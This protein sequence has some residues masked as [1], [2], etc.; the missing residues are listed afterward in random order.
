MRN[1]GRTNRLYRQKSIGMLRNRYPVK[2]T[3]AENISAEEMIKLDTVEFPGNIV[4]VEDTSD[5][6]SICTELSVC[7]AIGF[8]TETRP[9]FKPGIINKV[10]LLQL[11]TQDTCYLFRLCRIPLHKA[12]IKVLEDKNI[13]KIGADVHNDLLALKELRHFK[14][15]GFLDLQDIIHEWGITEKS[16]RKMSSIVLG[17]RVS[18]AKRLSNWAAV[19]LTP[20]QMMYAATDA[21][22]CLRIYDI[23]KKTEKKPLLPKP[24]AGGDKTESRAGK[25]RE[26]N[27]KL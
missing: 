5:I 24:A 20:R 16:V 1:K 4:V 18:K 10:A 9:S 3:F 13:I 6:E 22:V 23:L 25:K 7:P 19:S 2:N 26:V 27:G 8:D 21:W 14:P 17:E 11:S 12:I 15:G